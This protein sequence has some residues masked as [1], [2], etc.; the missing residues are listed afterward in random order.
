MKESRC[1]LPVKAELSSLSARTKLIPL[2]FQKGSFVLLLPLIACMYFPF[3]VSATTIS[4]SNFNSTAGLQL[5]GAA[6]PVATGDGNVVRLAYQNAQGGSLFTTNPVNVSQFSTSFSFRISAAGGDAADPSGQN[7][8][9]GFTF[10]I[11]STSASIVGNNGGGIGYGGILQSLAVEF[12]TWL[13]D[14]TNTADPNSNHIGID[15]NGSVKSL[16]STA[17][18][19]PRF[20]DGN[21]W[22]AWIDYDGTTLEIRAN[23]SGSE[24][25]LP[26]LQNTMNI[27][28]LINGDMAYVGFTSGTGGS[29]GNHDI[30]SWGLKETSPVPEPTTMLLLGTGIVGLAWSR[31]RGKK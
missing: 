11:Q 27:P 5:N 15:V 26:L 16:N 2:R 25:S 8:A 28:N 30:L 19:E 29:W 9:D 18:I 20:D 24:P 14:E 13:N 7:G 21:V 3:D 31:L 17:L 22:Y 23:Q 6:I 10:T 1:T 12:D 4:F